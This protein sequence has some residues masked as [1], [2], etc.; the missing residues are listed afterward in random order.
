MKGRDRHKSIKA[1]TNTTYRMSSIPHNAGN[2][3]R[4]VIV[5]L[6]E[7]QSP[8]AD[9]VPNLKV[10]ENRPVQIGVWVEKLL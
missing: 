9:L 1:E 3:L 10:L 7:P 6:M 4:P 8:G 5:R 2:P